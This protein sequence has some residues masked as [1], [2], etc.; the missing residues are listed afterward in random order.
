MNHRE[1]SA[2]IITNTARAGLAEKIL[3]FVVR[4]RGPRVTRGSAGGDVLVWPIKEVT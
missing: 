1:P 4:D 2:I 3:R